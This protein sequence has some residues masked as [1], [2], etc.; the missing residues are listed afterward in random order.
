MGGSSAGNGSSIAGG[1]SAHGS[2]SQSKSAAGSGDGASQLTRGTGQKSEN[3]GALSRAQ[4]KLSGSSAGRKQRERGRNRHDDA[5]SVALLNEAQ[6][7]LVTTLKQHGWGVS[8]VAGGRPVWRYAPA[9]ALLAS[10]KL[11][12][13]Q[14]RARLRLAAAVGKANVHFL[15]DAHAVDGS[16]DE[17]GMAIE[18]LSI[19]GSSVGFAEPTHVAELLLFVVRSRSAMVYEREKDVF[20]AEAEEAALCGG[21]GFARGAIAGVP[22]WLLLRRALS[23]AVN[24]SWHEHDLVRRCLLAMSRESIRMR[25]QSTRP[26]SPP[27]RPIRPRVSIEDYPLATVASRW[28]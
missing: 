9:A 14:A 11:R 13:L 24:H 19:F 25:E 26:S 3:T 8:L 16:S 28:R 15:A 4:T 17:R 18:A 1:S 27:L 10:V 6:A 23:L 2:A 12:I 7:A 20:A 5:S 22:S 21:H